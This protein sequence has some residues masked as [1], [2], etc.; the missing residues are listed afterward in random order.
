MGGK[1]LSEIREMYTKYPSIPETNFVVE[2]KDAALARLESA[3]A[4]AEFDRL[5]GLTGTLSSGSWFNV[6]ASNTEPVLR[7]NAEANSQQD[8]DE[9][10]A[11]ATQLI[12]EA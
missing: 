3:F 7:L 4:G 2:D 9:L 1:K 8:L 11:K 10:V 12:T 5:D 6:R